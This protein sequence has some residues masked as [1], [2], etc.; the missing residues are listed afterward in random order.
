MDQPPAPAEIEIAL[1]AFG[2]LHGKAALRFGLG[3]DQIGQRLGLDQIELAVEK[4]AAREFARFGMADAI[5][6]GDRLQHLAGDGA[7]AMDM[8]FGDVLAGKAVRTREKQHQ[9]VVD[10]RSVGRPELAQGGDRGP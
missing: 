8:E 7:A 4:G 2:I 1:R 9:A 5:K 6:A 10:Q 3:V